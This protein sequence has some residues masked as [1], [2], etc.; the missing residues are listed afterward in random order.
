MD[1]RCLNPLDWDAVVASTK[2][3]N[4]ILTVTEEPLMNSFAE[5]LAGRISQHC[6]QDL[7]APVMTIGA[8]NLPAVPLNVDLERVMLPN[9]IKVEQILKELLNY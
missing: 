1:L 6:F 8:K 7:D 3:H 5:S 4:K 9:A 2:K